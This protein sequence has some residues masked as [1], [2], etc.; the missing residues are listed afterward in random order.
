MLVE[1]LKQQTFDQP[2]LIQRFEEQMLVHLLRQTPH[3]QL[4]QN[5]VNVT[6]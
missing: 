2:L 1:L 3:Q 5:L 4:Y 6:T